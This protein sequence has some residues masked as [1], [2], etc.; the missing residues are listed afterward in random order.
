M[1]NVTTFSAAA[2]LAIP[3]SEPERLFTGD[4]DTAKQEFRALATRWHPDRCPDAETTGVFQHVN[5]LYDSA[6]RKLRGGVW[7]APGL[8]T[9][10]ATDGAAYKIRY[11]KE[12]EF[13]LGRLFIGREI[14]TY[15][16]DKEHSDLFQNALQTIHRLP[17]ANARMAAEVERY[18]PEIIRHFD[19]EDYRVLVV[20]KAPDWVLLRDVLDHSGGSMDARHVA[21]IVSSLL[22]LACYLDYARLAH[23]AILTDTYFISPQR[24]SGALLGGWWYAVPQGQRLL[25]APAA[26]VQYAPFD[27]MTRKCG[28]IRTDLEMVR[29][30]GRELLG[31]MTGIRLTSAKAAPQ[32]LLDWLRL[33]ASGSALNDYKTWQRQVLRDSFGARRFV[34]LDVSATDLY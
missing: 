1:N 14:A 32:P 25:A 20:K 10:R 33:P 6:L 18:L 12:H 31:D 8:L 16:V 9:L 13:E 4:E 2:L 7:Q 29:A 5:R 3:L 24:H 26:T 28:D 11:R 22:N 30:L 17:C 23:N 15:V 34:K 27:V 19:T 21:W